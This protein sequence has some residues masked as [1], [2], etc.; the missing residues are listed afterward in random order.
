MS[1]ATHLRMKSTSPDSIQHSRTSG[2]ARTK[3][4]NARRSGI[5]LAGQMDRGEHRDVEA[6]PARIQQAPV[7]LDVAVFLQ[8]ADTA[9]AGGR[10]NADAFGQ[11]DI[12]DSAVGLDL[13]EDFEVDFVQILRHARR[14]P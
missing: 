13:G 4:S 5:R 10:R 2:S 9:Q 6:E 3:S 14:V 8:R 7:A 11:F 12:G 1:G